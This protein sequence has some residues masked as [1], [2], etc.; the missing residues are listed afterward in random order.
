MKI[1]P[2]L[3]FAGRTEE[4]IAFYGKALGARLEM[5]LRFREAPQP[6]P[7]GSLPPGFDDKVMHASFRIGES[8]V[9]ASDGPVPPPG[10]FHGFSLSLSVADEAEADRVFAALG[11]GGEVR[12]P[13]GRTFFSPRFGMLVDR[14]GVHWIVIVPAAAP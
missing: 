1:E 4:A 11:A 10:G 14:F 8:V 2:Y 13:L 12:V 3:F 6:P 7:P 9:M 5:L